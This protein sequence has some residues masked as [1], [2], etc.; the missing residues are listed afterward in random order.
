MKVLV[1]GA[2]GKTGRLVVDRA[3]A[4]GHEVTALLRDPSKFRN[5]GIRVLIGDATSR[6][7][8]LKVMK[9]QDAVID[10]IG[11]ATPY[12]S[13][14]LESTSVRNMIDAM[15]HEGVRRLVVVSMMGI[16]ASR[17]QAPFWYKYLLMPTFLHG[18]TKDKSLMERE[19]SASNL[20]YI[21]V[22]P[23]ILKDDAPKGSVNVLKD[24]TIG[25]AITRAD[26]ADFLVDQLET[27]T[28]LRQAVTVVNT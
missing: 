13:T 9:G 17:S 22:R 6:A 21:I 5:K 1:F 25:H 7:D 18:S 26:L 28:H 12:K 24:N 19:V 14:R 11:G 2:A 27:D 20:D 10:S 8:V 3:L 15:Q 23:P 16:G 4:K